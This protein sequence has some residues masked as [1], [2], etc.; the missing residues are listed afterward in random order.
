MVAVVV[1]EDPE[2]Q[3]VA[4][5]PDVVARGDV[6]DFA[7]IDEQLGATARVVGDQRDALPLARLPKVRAG[8]AVDAAVGRREQVVGVVGI[9][10]VT[11]EETEVTVV[12]THRHEQVEDHGGF[13]VLGVGGA[14]PNA[15]AIG[16]A[17]VAVKEHVAD[18][19]AVDVAWRVRRP[20]TRGGA[21]HAGVRA[22]VSFLHLRDPAEAVD[23]VAA[24]AGEAP[25]GGI[26]GQVDKIGGR[27]HDEG[28]GTAENEYSSRERGNFHT[29]ILAENGCAARLK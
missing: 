27:G 17:G 12:V 4:A 15:V 3:A 28:E 20:G 7:A 6:G 25:L 11:V 22:H 29:V 19:L 5:A 10:V 21:E 14:R 8:V 9:G 18:G 26:G 23:E 13:L 2:V 1:R 16:A 24:A